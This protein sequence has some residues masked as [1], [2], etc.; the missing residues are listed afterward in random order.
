MLQGGEKWKGSCLQARRKSGGIMSLL[1]SERPMS[2]KEM[3]LSLWVLNL[4]LLISKGSFFVKEINP[5]QLCV[6]N[7]I[8]KPVACFYSKFQVFKKFECN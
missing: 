2:S 7:I 3:E 5:Y 1:E 4:F 6:I 8:S